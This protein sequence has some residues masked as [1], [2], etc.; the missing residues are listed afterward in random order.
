MQ[1]CFPLT[2]KKG[3]LHPFF[4]LISV[5]IYIMNKNFGLLI[6]GKWLKNKKT[7]DVLNPFDGKKISSVSIADSKEINNSIKSAHLAFQKLVKN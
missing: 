6:N 4:F 2:A 1:A 7:I 3:C 5:Y